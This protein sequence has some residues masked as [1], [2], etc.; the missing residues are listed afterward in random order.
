MK[1][2]RPE[3]G[4]RLPLRQSRFVWNLDSS[5]S[6]AVRQAT[7]PEDQGG[8]EDNLCRLGDVVSEI[9]ADVIARRYDV[10]RP[11]A[12]VVVE[13]AFHCAGEEP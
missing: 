8:E 7:A 3:V 10:S 9:L 13:H 2:P 4:T 11:Y 1:K 12:R 5:L 6:T